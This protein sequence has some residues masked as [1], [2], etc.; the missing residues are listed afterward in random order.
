MQEHSIRISL[1]TSFGLEIFL[2]TNKIIHEALSERTNKPGNIHRPTHNIKPDLNPDYHMHKYKLEDIINADEIQSILDDF[3]RLTNMVTAVLDLNGKVIEATG[4]QDLC[5]GFH[6]VNPLTA[7]N[8]TESDL[9]LAKNLRPGEYVAYKCKNGLWDVVTP[10]FIGD[11][12]LGNIYTGQ[13]FYDDDPVDDGFFAKQAETYG[14]DKTAYM[15]ALR[16][17]PRYSRETVN[18][19]MSFLVKL[20]TYISKISLFNMQLEEE[21]RERKQIENALKE[22]EAQLRTLTRTIPD[23]V[24]LKDS[25]GKYL[26]C[27][28][29]FES[30]FGAQEKNII[31]KTD[32]DFMDKDLAD[33][34]RKHDKAAV[35][36]GKASINEEEVT[37]ADDGHREILETIK[38]PI[39]N[40][41]GQLAGVLGIGRDI[42]GR[43]QAELAIA[44]E[45]ERLAVTLRS[46]GDGV[47]TTDSDGNI[48]LLNKAAEA[49]TGWN[50]REAA[51]RPLPEVF[52][53]INEHTRKQ[54][55]NPVEKV[56]ATGGTVELAN[57][58]CL[59][60]KDGREIVIADSG[61]PIYDNESKI[62]GAVLVF[63]D[64][65][66]KQELEHSIQRAQKLESLGVLA[67]GIAHDFNNLLGG[68]F[69]HVE[70]ALAETTEEK[71]SSCLAESL[72]SIDRARALT[73]QLLI[74]AKG[75]A[76]IKKLDNLFPFVQKTVQFALSGS[77]VSSKIKVQKNLWP[78]DFDKNQ[79]SQVI[80]N[81]AIN[82]QQAMPNGGKI[83][84]S[85][86][87]ISLAEKEHVSLAA[88]KYVKLSIKDEGIGIPKE[89][90]PRIFDP[91]YTT[92]FKGHGLGL[93]T[94]YSIVNRHG[95]CIDVESEPGKGSTFHVYLPASIESVA[96]MAKITTGKHAGSGTFLV[97]DDEPSIR[98]IIKKMLESFGYEVVLKKNGKDAIEFFAKEMKANRNLAGMIFDLTIPGGMGG[99]EAIGEIR[100]ICPNTPAFVASGYSADPIMADP[101]KYGFNASIRKPF[102]KAE[103]SEMLEKHLE[104]GMSTPLEP[105]TE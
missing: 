56:F 76:P 36:K 37:F 22:R 44:A 14:F 8:C 30:F 46:I 88:G 41:N 39:Y 29:R 43:K 89:F 33:F 99:K 74:F 58:T 67:G 86:Q 52:N 80:D 20:T 38:T 62:I 49:L 40:S 31:G 4:W 53:I 25:Q 60:A 66:E 51:G 94:C 72:S 78:C 5:T 2:M 32:Y 101:E 54:C 69:G 12:H 103:L 15:D 3:H 92:K 26:F 23:L 70:L 77:S 42:T 21:I 85:A 48:V 11:K 45:K 83:E 18:N 65:T 81:I 97:M 27:N 1:G 17:I 75:G 35:D 61:A 47:I 82:A 96:G 79:I 28:S 7:R 64:M 63:R 87:N 84:V 6:R 91:Y 104:G 34:F 90:L 55:E 50:S 73:Q 16:R 98:D 71:V 93:S 59:V 68:I 102:M 9:F 13:F 95:G 100:K 10:L 105:S 24:W 19:L 57:H